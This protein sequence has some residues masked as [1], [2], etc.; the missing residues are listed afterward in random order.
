M[1]D[2]FLGLGL[3]GLILEEKFGDHRQPLNNINDNS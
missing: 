3:K 2:H 1:F